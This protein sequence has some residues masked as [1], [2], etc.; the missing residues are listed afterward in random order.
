MRFA[1]LLQAAVS[2]QSASSPAGSWQAVLD[3]AGGALPFE[4]TISRSRGGWRGELSNLNSWRAFSAV[5]V[6]SDS[7]VLEMADYDATIRASQ[8]GDSLH[9]YYHNVGS[10]GPRT[11]PFRASRGRR[12]DQKAPRSLLGRWDATYFQESGTSPRVFDFRN[13]PRGFEGRIISS[14]TDYGPFLGDVAAES[15]AIGLFDGSFVYLLTGRLDGDTLR[16][17]F[18]A[19]LRTQTQWKAVRSTGRPHLRLPTEITRADTTEPIRF[20]FPDLQ[21]RLVRSDDVQFKGKVVLLDVFGSWCPTCHEATPELLR[22]FRRY[23][24][25]GLEMVGLAFEATGDT[26]VDARQVRRYRDKF[27]IPFPLLLAGVN[28]S[29][30]MAAALPQLRD[31]SAFPTTIFVGRDGRV[32]RVHAGFH[33]LAAGP[34]HQRMVREFEQEIERLLQEHVNGER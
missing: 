2:A 9:G 24:P 23:H 17:T 34:Q 5:Y 18:H 13:G 4:M 28:D 25:R 7:V 6:R 31:L 33:G 29:E 11:I 19:G 8:R 10:S 15:F 30:S 32:R 12:P 3:L 20:A 26:A 14:T 1:L 22:I 21:G 16:G 27:R